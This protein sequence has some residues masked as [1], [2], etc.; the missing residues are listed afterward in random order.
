MDAFENNNPITLSEAAKELGIE[1]DEAAAIL[2]KNAN[3]SHLKGDAEISKW[4]YSL[5]EIIVHNRIE[6]KQKLESE[7]KGLPKDSDLFP[8]REN[9]MCYCPA[10]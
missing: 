4:Q 3:L 1:I 7:L 9:A 2:K 6:E 5:L 8:P 10:R